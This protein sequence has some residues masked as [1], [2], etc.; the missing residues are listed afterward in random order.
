MNRCSFGERAAGFDINDEAATPRL[1]QRID[2]RLY[3]AKRRVQARVDLMSR[4]HR[5]QMF[6]NPHHCPR[7]K[8]YEAFVAPRFI[9]NPAA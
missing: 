1:E 8:S 5:P 9:G 3:G 4:Q 7:L 6:V 2:R